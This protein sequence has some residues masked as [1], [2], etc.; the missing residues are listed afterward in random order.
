M[1]L[2][3]VTVQARHIRRVRGASMTLTDGS[4][5]RP[6]AGLLAF[7]VVVLPVYLTLILLIAGLL[8][9]VIPPRWGIAGAMLAVVAP[10]SP[11]LV[12]LAARIVR[13]LRTPEARTLGR[14]HQEIAD[15]SD[16]PVLMMTSFVR[17]KQPGEGPRLLHAL[18]TEWDRTGTVV[19]LNPAN[20]ALGR[21]VET[22]P[23][24][25]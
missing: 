12:E 17:S 2:L 15:Q 19:I 20:R 7:A 16:R 24:Y 22:R 21:Y 23:R 1:D 3:T 5:R 4:R 10:M 18:R 14:R 25:R 6:D 8:T 11:L 9:A 13:L